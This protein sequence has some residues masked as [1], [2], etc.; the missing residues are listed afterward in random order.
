MQ[1]N[2]FPDFLG[3]YMLPQ[4]RRDARQVHPYKSAKNPVTNQLRRD[5][6]QVHPYKWAPNPHSRPVKVY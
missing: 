1:L 6:R 3:A 2:T 5:A 4:L